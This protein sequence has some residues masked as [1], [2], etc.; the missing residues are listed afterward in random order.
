M[1]S[2]NTPSPQT[3]NSPT[4]FTA[5]PSENAA[6]S[7]LRETVGK[8]RE[9]ATSTAATA[10]DKAAAIA[11]D[12]KNAAAER[13]AGYS[14]RL[15]EAAR[16]AEEAQDPNI[17][18]FAEE[19]ANRLERVADYLRDAD[20]GRLRQDATQLARKHPALFLG[21]M[22]VAGLVLG[23]LA[24]ASVQSL[25]NAGEKDRDNEPDDDNSSRQ[26]EF[27]GFPAEARANDD[28]VATGAS[29]ENRSAEP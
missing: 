7:P 8:V 6:G 20:F 13:V 21:G 5:K 4:A 9:A 1:N 14:D 2:T 28:F 26:R 18:H 19:A 11:G 29:V 10:K 22:L 24:K 15:R 12:G 17:A 27:D 25:G 23:N 16:S 3:P